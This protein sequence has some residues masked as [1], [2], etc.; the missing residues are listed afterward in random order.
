MEALKGCYGLFYSFELPS[1]NPTYD[2]F[3]G[4][5]EVRAAHNVLEACARTDT[6][7]KLILTSSA[8]AVIW[9]DQH[10]SVPSDLWHGLS[11]TVVEKT[12]WA[13]A[14]DRE[15]NMVSINAGLLMHPN[16]SIK[17]PYLL[18][19]TE[20][21]KDPT[22]IHLYDIALAHVSIVDETSV[23]SLVRWL[24]CY[25]NIKIKNTSLVLLKYLKMFLTA[26]LCFSPG[27]EKNKVYE[28]RVSRKKLSKLMVGFDSELQTE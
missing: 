3:I 1:D 26:I 15:V 28:Q 4:E 27:L 20:I 11:K 23:P 24:H 19:A 7:D 8:T 10:N 21:F 13:M 17:D 25:H 12:A 2:E 14:M 9:R 22:R 18:G 6:I 16:L 5:I